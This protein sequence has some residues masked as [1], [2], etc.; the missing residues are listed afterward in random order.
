MHEAEI[1]IWYKTA[2]ILEWW[3]NQFLNLEGIDIISLYRFL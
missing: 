3:T 2:V 1:E